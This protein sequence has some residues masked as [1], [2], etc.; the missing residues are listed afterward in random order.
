M[1]KRVHDLAK[2]LEKEGKPEDSAWAI[3]TAALKKKKKK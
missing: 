1:P 3:A 2:K